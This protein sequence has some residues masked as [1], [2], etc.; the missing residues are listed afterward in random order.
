MA[1]LDTDVSFLILTILI[2]PLSPQGRVPVHLLYQSSELH[3]PSITGKNSNR[4]SGQAELIK[5]TDEVFRNKGGTGWELGRP[6][7]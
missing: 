3:L 2:A 1:F 5:E 7:L 6:L 4:K